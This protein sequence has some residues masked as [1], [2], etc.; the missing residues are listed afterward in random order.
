MF[1]PFNF[2]NFRTPDIEFNRLIQSLCFRRAATPAIAVSLPACG[3]YE[4]G[5]LDHP[6]PTIFGHP[7]FSWSPEF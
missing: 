5:N 7:F 6:Q 1:G 3:A 2:S 4:S